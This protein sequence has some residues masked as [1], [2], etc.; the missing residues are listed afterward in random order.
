LRF[1]FAHEVAAFEEGGEA[2]DVEW[3]CWHRHVLESR[4]QTES[5]PYSSRLK[6]ETRIATTIQRKLRQELNIY[7]LKVILNILA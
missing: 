6:A 4:L 2:D 5:V 3:C 1:A 7:S